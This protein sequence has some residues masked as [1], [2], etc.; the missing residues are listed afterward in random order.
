MKN[1]VR[2]VY[3]HISEQHLQKYVD[4]FSFKQNTRLDKGMFDVLLN[5]CVLSQS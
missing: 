2:G 5:Q 1:G 3:H 4:E